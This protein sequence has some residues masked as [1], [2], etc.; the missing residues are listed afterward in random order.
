MPGKGRLGSWAA[1]GKGTASLQ[2]PSPVLG[3][4]RSQP[5]QSPTIL[6]VS[7]AGPFRRNP[8]ASGESRLARSV[9][10][11]SNFPGPFWILSP[12]WRRPA[13][14]RTPGA[15]AIPESG[16]GNTLTGLSCFL[17]R[18]NLH[19]GGPHCPDELREAQVGGHGALKL[20]QS[21]VDSRL[22]LSRRFAGSFCRVLPALISP[23]QW[24]PVLHPKDDGES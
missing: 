13:R 22:E 10:P 16:G 9:S 5:T 14:V 20:T 8:Q 19:L 11:A 18:L 1:L 3:P 24:T 23:G 15:P 2:A 7:P 12:R 6:A 17:W 4:Q 21:T